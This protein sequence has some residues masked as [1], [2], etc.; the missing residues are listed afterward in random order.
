MNF[1][2]AGDLHLTHVGRVTAQVGPFRNTA[3]T[4]ESQACTVVWMTDDCAGSCMTQWVRPTAPIPPWGNKAL[5][6]ATARGKSFPGQALGHRPAY[7]GGPK[8]GENQAILKVHKYLS[9]SFRF[10][11][12][13][14]SSWKLA[15]A[16]TLAWLSTRYFRWECTCR[17]K[18]VGWGEGRLSRDLLEAAFLELFKTGHRQM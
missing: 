11:G 9:K 18:E 14:H 5:E 17:T 6:G 8:M 13:G 16:H 7:Q 1:A 12:E 4:N 10:F 15:H 2:H 3:V